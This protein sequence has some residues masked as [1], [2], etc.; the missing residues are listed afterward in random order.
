MKKADAII[1][2]IVLISTL[3][4]WCFREY[5]KYLVTNTSNEKYVEIQVK[6]KVNKIIPLAK[7]TE[8]TIPIE[9]E[10][11]SNTIVI[12]EEIVEMHD[13]DCPDQICVHERPVSEVGSIIVC[14][15]HKVVIEIKGSEE[16][17][18]DGISN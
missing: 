1:V 10:F 3:M 6:G 14:L 12:D 5:N 18:I 8:K 13:A 16:P 9:T 11:G 2:V 17:N 15:P 7:N 4:F